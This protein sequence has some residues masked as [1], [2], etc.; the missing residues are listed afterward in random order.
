MITNY[1]E[2][3]KLFKEIDKTVEKKINLFGS[4]RNVLMG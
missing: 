2:I 4:S 3:E 1:D